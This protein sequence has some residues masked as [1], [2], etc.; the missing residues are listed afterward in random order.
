MSPTWVIG[1]VCAFGLA[2]L[3]V[4]YDC[5]LAL[6]IS[7][8]R[9]P[10]TIIK[11]KEACFVSCCAGVIALTAFQFTTGRG[12]SA[13]D[14]VLTLKQPQDV[15]RGISVGLTVLVLIRSKLTTVKV[16]NSEVNLS[17]CQHGAGLL[18]MS[19]RTGESINAASTTGI[20]LTP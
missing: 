19:T 17:T 1:S 4:L 12:D 14:A 20:W 10:I 9:V 11:S 13:I 18:K 3:T 16:V 8:K 5:H 2:S 6:K 7:L 15:L